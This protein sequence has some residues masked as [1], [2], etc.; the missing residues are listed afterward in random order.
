L[1]SEEKKCYPDN[2]Q[3]LYT[4]EEQLRNAALSLVTEDKNLQLH[5][6]TI[7]SAMNMIDCI[8]QYESLDEDFRT[9]QM[10]G[11]R[12]FN[13]LGASLKLALSGYSQN[14]A[15]IQRDILETVF[16]LDLFRR[17]R[18][19]IAQ[20]RS[21]SKAD[22]LKNFKPVKVRLRLDELDCFTLKNR[23]AL[24]NAFSELAGHPNVNSVLLLRPTRDGNALIGPFIAKETFN[25]IITEM[26]KLSLQAGE[27]ISAFFPPGWPLGELASAHFNEVKAKWLSTFFG[28]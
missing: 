1:E 13:A 6:A 16:L 3:S 25:A 19:L 4:A 22:R 11:I 17:E 2:L 14:C 24:Y 15:L 5:F 12:I 27:H 10:L 20:W 7:E 18:H 23:E 8:R 26:G 9:I 28:R 21:S